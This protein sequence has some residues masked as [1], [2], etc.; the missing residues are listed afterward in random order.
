MKSSNQLSG[1]VR[2]SE[3]SL[4]WRE[5]KSGAGATTFQVPRMSGIRIR[6]TT[7]G[8]TVSFDGVLSATMAL[9]EV[10]LFNS[11]NGALFGK[12]IDTS[13]TVTLVVSSNCFIQVGCEVQSQ[14]ENG[15]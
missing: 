4:T 14:W 13:S 6:S 9:D 7:A 1:G 10:M 5:I 11:G 2:S 12:V 8:L 3:V 15:F